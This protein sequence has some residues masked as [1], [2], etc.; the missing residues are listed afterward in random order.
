M[1]AMLKDHGTKCSRKFLASYLE[2]QG[3]DFV[4]PSHRG[5][6]GGGGGGAGGSFVF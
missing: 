2:N 4:R 5:R 1:Q 6:F 3:I